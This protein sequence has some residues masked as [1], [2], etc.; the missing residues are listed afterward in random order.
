MLDS[1]LPGGSSRAEA[2]QGRRP[3]SL[4][5]QV[6]TISCPSPPTPPTL[7]Q[8]TLEVFLFFSFNCCL[9]WWLAKGWEI[10]YAKPCKPPPHPSPSLQ[11]F[12]KKMPF[13]A[14]PTSTTGATECSHSG[15]R[16][17][18]ISQMRNWEML[19]HFWI[20]SQTRN[21]IP[22]LQRRM[23]VLP[24]SRRATYLFQDVADNFRYF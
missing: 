4:Q 17:S 21:S 16:D 24:F 15:E 11:G 12:F 3:F 1:L 13:E 9:K 22:L 7:T 5:R 14:A 20:A 2:L 8:C 18:L 6:S 19:G 10:N 23:W